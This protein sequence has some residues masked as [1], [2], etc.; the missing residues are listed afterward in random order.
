MDEKDSLYL[1]A[2]KQFEKDYILSPY[3]ADI[4]FTIAQFLDQQGQL[5]DPV[6]SP[7]HKW[8]IKE[9]AGYCENAVTRFP[10]SDGAKNCR[11]L[12]KSIQQPYLQLT[13]ENSV[14]PGKPFLSLLEFNNVPAVYFRLIKTDPEVNRDKTA[15]LSRENLINYYTGLS[16]QASWSQDLP[17]DGDFQKHSSEISVPGVPAGF[18]I[19]LGSSDP[20]FNETGQVIAFVPV[21]VT[22]LSYISLHNESGGLDFYIL[23]R[24]T[25]KPLK[26]VLA[27]SFVKV[28]NYSSRSYDIQKSGEYRTD[29]NG[30]FTIPVLPQGAN[31]N[32]FYLKLQSGNDLLMTDNYYQYP[33]GKPVEKT[34]LQ[35][36]FFTDR[37]IYRPGQTIYF[38]GV[39]LEKT[40]D[41]YEIKPGTATTVTLKDAN[42]Q[43]VSEQLFTS[44]DYGSFNGSFVAPQGVL[45]GQMTIG[46]GSGSAV[47]RV[48]EYK[49]PTFEVLFEPMEGNYMLDDTVSVVAKAAA[50]A[51]NPVGGAKVRY[52]VVRTARFPYWRWW[53][54]YPASPEIEI[55]NGETVTGNDGALNV[56]FHAIPDKSI[57]Q[58]SFP[59]FD[60]RILVDVTDVNGETQPAEE[61]VSVGYTSLLIGIGI[62][63]KLNIGTDSVFQITSTNLNGRKTP[64]ELKITLQRLKQ[65]ENLYRKRAWSVPDLHLIPEKEFRSQ[66]PND[67]YSDEDNPAKWTIRE[68]LLEKIFNTASDS[69]FR[70]SDFAVRV[71]SGWKMV[72]GTLLDPGEYRLTMTAKDPSGTDVVSDSY[73][74][75]FS[76]VSGEIPVNSLN[77]FV[78]L[79]TTCEPGEKAQFLLGSK[80]DIPNVIYVIRVHDSLVSRQWLKLN[81]NQLFVEIPVPEK[82]RGGFQVTFLYVV[83]NRS[84]QNSRFVSV[85]YTNKMLDI[86]FETFRNKIYPGQDEEWRLKITDAAKKGVEAELVASMYD[87][88]LDAFVPHDWYFSLYRIYYSYLS[89]DINDAFTSSTGIYYPLSPEG[90]SYIYH[91]YDRLNWFGFGPSG[92]YGRYTRRGGKVMM[93]EELSKDKT[94]ELPM[95][96][97]EIGGMTSGEK[98]PPPPEAKTSISGNQIKE[99]PSSSA[100][101]VQIR[102]NFRETAFFYSSLVSD[103][104]GNLILK[105]KA[106]E[107]LTRWKFMGLAYTKQLEYGQ[108][109]QELV[110]RKELMI[111]P[112]TPRFVRQGDTVVFSSKI[113][114][115]S[116]HDLSGEVMLVLTDALTNKSLDYIISTGINTLSFG[117]PK[118][119]STSISWKFIV[120]QEPTLSLLQYRV[121]AVAGNFS[122]GEEKIIPVLTNR[123]LVTESLPLPVRGSGNFNFIFGKLFQSGSSQTQK[124][125][126]LTLEFASNPAWYTV[127]ALSLLDEPVYPSADNIFNAYYANSIASFLANSNPEIRKVFE[128]WKNLTPDALLSNLEKNQQLK[129]ALIQETPWVLEAKSESERKR[130]LGELFDPNNLSRKLTD[131]LQK[132]Q[133]M[134]LPNGGWTWFEGMQENRYI[135]QNIVTG[136]GRLDHLGIKEIRT[137]PDTWNMMAKAIVYLDGEMTRDYN[138]IKKHSPGYNTED[139]LGSTDI[140]YLYARSYFMNDVP[141][142]STGKWKQS[143]VKEAFDYFV[144]QTGIYWLKKDLSFQGMIALALNRLGNKDIPQRILK[145]LSEK[146]LHSEEMGMYWVMQQGYEWYQ[147]PVETQALLIEAFDE[148]A[149]DR[150]SVDEM[151]IWLLKQKQT[152]DWRTGRATAEAC[153]ALLLRGA[154]L[155]SAEPDVTIHVGNETID[156]LKLQDNRAEAGTGYFQVSWSGKEIIPEM[157]KISVDKKGEGIAWG[158]LYWQ[159]FEDLDKITPAKT[160]LKVDKKLFVEKNTPSGPVLEPITIPMAIGNGFRITTGDKIKVRIILTVDRNLEFV[161]M[162]DMR[163]SSFEPPVGESLSG[164]RYQDGLGY[165]QSTTDLATNFFFDWLPKGTYVFEYPL[166][167]NAAGEYSNGITTVQC[168][169]A[170][171]F[172]AHSEGIRV[173]VP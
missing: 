140:Q 25:G 122:D 93:A 13:V 29:L 128:S 53:I 66:F 39:L 40:K 155:L 115:L 142:A 99:K 144:R 164:Y 50:Y 41:H 92:Y 69:V 134:Q 151:K 107:S 163:A 103:S 97:N 146:A 156:P 71:K 28:Y 173:T 139:H 60:Y 169:Y 45:L 20:K 170:P 10:E 14:I 105:F 77:W 49:R 57:E 67:V 76:P 30:F 12:L 125:F 5:Y 135:T 55:I 124:N 149:G 154:D 17:S 147:A 166:V 74:T 31:Y 94:V 37:A 43:K 44:N 111:F 78:P 127:Q 153:Y 70:F 114:N 48:E 18:Y 113:V 88:S 91:E 35:T 21:F 109:E 47:I 42:Y 82:Y 141:L 126:R 118:G 161:H 59:V 162:K 7:K 96:A 86:K 61:T 117:T 143:Q 145:S 36:F 95:A 172:S 138:E 1:A 171:E 54:P 19:L 23:D 90:T 121:V 87:A 168:M 46:N 129:S 58:S 80:E 24:E 8:D 75:V 157:G 79:N 136:L 15:S 81:G 16:F 119:Q 27:E 130:K 159:Y 110:T 51:G 120:P 98:P 11:Q 165:Y 167:V 26:D 160:P 148:V 106:P 132:L 9:A 83:H 68:L 123:M 108:I 33:I 104:S 100:P 116:D 4:T 56:K 65:P 3:S 72:N 22:N 85:P 137:D 84:F 64:V 150:K 152:Q 52:R 63:D 32:N 89:W 158:A 133:T 73:F 62:P 112:N 38:K 2:L 34:V 131:Y 101:V 102:R 6:V